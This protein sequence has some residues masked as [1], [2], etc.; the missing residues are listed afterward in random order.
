M[1]NVRIQNSTKFLQ[2][3]KLS[4]R[5]SYSYFHILIRIARNLSVIFETFQN[6][7]RNLLLRLPSQLNPKQDQHNKI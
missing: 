1:S 5:V 6:S 7:S 3:R 2:F 4:G